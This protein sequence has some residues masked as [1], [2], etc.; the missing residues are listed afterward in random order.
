VRQ[1]LSF[2][3]GVHLCMGAPIARMEA[4]IAMRLL[5]ERLPR[6]RLL[7]RGERVR[8][9]MYWGRASLPLAWD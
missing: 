6:L 5:L 3:N 7:G 2:G 1:H 4:R 9:W 8:T